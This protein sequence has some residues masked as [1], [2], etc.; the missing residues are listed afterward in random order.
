M[1]DTAP[2]LGVIFTLFLFLILAIVYA[3]IAAYVVQTYRRAGWVLRKW[4]AD[5][6]FRIIDSNR[7]LVRKGPFFFNSSQSQ[8]VYRVTVEDAQGSIRHGWVRCGS[9][10]LGPWKDQVDVKWD[11]A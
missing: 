11:E 9:F 5:N 10:F 6:G 2:A 1:R 8:I 4:A 3:G 7:P